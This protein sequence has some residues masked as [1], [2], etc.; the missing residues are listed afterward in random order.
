MI[1]FLHEDKFTVKS[2]T[3]GAKSTV[4]IDTEDLTP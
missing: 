3:S 4:L 1:Y 2:L